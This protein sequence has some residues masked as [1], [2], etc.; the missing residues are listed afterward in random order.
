MTTVNLTNFKYFSGIYYYTGMS[1]EFH[2][3][4]RVREMKL[5]SF[6]CLGNSNDFKTKNFILFLVWF[7]LNIHS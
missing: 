4:D 2:N 7:D 1:N 5:S 3:S 6:Y